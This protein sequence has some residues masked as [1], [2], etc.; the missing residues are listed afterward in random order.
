MKTLMLL[1]T[2]YDAR[3]VLPVET[4]CKDYFIHLTPEKFVRKCSSGEI[5]LPLIRME[6][7]QKCAKGVHLQDLADYLDARRAAALKEAQQLAA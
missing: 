5:R 7:S 2:Q 6:G 4:V 1:M 3:A